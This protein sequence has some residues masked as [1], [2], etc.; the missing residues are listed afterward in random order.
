MNG[1]G[2][3]SHQDI[4]VL[5]TIVHKRE[6]VKILRMIQETDPAA[7]VSQSRAEGVYG[8]GFNVIKP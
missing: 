2:Y 7:F 4:K 1:E 5:I 3:Y 6:S 8:N